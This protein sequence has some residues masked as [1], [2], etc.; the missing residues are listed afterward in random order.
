MSAK[1]SES[2]VRGPGR[3]HAL[4]IVSILC[5]FAPGALSMSQF[6]RFELNGKPAYG[7]LEGEK[8][9]RLEGDLFGEWKKTEETYD[10]SKAK[11]LVPTQASK[12]LALA[13]NYRDHLGEIPVPAHPEPFFK[14]PTCLIATGQS[15]LIPKGTEDVHYELELVVVIGKQAKNVSQDEALDYVLGV[16]AGCDV[17]AR[18]W[19]KN[20]RQW[21]RAKGA[22]TFGPCGPV[23]LSGGDYQ[24]LDME[25]KVNG[26]T[27]QKSNTGMMIHPIPDIVSFISQS[28]TLFPG[29]LIFTG[30]PGKTTAIHPGD[31]V[32]IEIEGIGKLTNPV[33]QD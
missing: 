7:L 6:V 11:L 14:P 18:D 23:I 19:Q 15:I 32:E 9:L 31:V 13:G 17:S 30:T 22:D 29:D 4:L 5:A 21:W 28:V 1:L 12:V 2:V 3:G 24:D 25:L 20:D 16:T 26:E 10:L 33:G 27:K 8:I